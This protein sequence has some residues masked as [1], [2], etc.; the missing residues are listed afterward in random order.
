[1]TLELHKIFFLVAVRLRYE[2]DH[3]SEHVVR[4][5]ESCGG[6]NRRGI[7]ERVY[8]RFSRNE[9]ASLIQGS[10]VRNHVVHLTQRNQYVIVF[11]KD[12][13]EP[14]VEPRGYDARG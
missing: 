5:M 7:C 13:V 3:L 9:Y 6:I 10:H 2:I 12:F 11:P 14:T 1:M 8:P 4:C